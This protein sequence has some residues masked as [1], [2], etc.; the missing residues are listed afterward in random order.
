MGYRSSRSFKSRINWFKN[1]SKLQLS[2]IA[3]GGHDLRQYASPVQV[4]HL[5]VIRKL[6]SRFDAVYER[7]PTLEQPLY[8][9]V[10]L[11]LR[12]HPA[13]NLAQCLG[14]MRV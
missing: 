3:E 4:V 12:V 11:G 10:S 7:I 6:V 13:Q 5:I 14:V 9:L 8:T 2:L 1:L